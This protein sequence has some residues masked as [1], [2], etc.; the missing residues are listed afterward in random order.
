[1][2]LLLTVV[3]ASTNEGKLAELRSLL[4]DLPLELVSYR[5]VAE[6]PEALAED[7]STF[8]ANATQ[9]ARSV[10]RATQLVSLADDSGLEVRALAGRPGVRSK[11]F[12]H[13]RATDAENNS[14][15]LHEMSALPEADRDAR[16]RC[17]LA[18]ATPWESDVRLREGVCSGRIAR[19]P[20]GRHGFGYDPLFVLE[21]SE[22]PAHAG[23]TL[24]ELEHAEKNAI[25]HRARAVRAL[26]PLL[27]EVL[28]REL[29]VAERICALASG[30]QRPAD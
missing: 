24:A 15:L 23:R 14:A 29:A 11:R 20:L 3:L 16:F 25:S 30:K 7:G 5:D 9:K 18:L 4:A 26:R 22:A 21:D 27:L 13:E 8:E 1:M 28:N 6:E 17:V 2:T 12:A 19:A 10:C